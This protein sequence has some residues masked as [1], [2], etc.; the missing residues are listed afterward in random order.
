MSFPL[1]S[2]TT[3][4]SAWIGCGL[5]CLIAV[6]SLADDP[7]TAPV[8]GEFPA[9]SDGVE[10]MGE[11]VA[12]DPNNRRG[13]LRPGGEVTPDRYN[14]FPGQPFALLPYGA[15]YYHGAPAE[16]KDIPPGTVLH[17]VFFRPPK[18]DNS[19]PKPE[20]KSVAERQR[21]AYF[22]EHTHALLLEDSVSY[23]GRQG[24]AWRVERIETSEQDG[25]QFLVVNSVGKKATAGP[26]GE[27]KFCIDKSSR[28]WKGKESR[29]LDDVQP[30]QTVQLNLTW[31]PAWGYGKFHVLDLWL[32]QQAL[33]VAAERQRQTHLRYQQHHWLPGW[34]DKV[35]YEPGQ[36]NGSGVVEVTLFAG[37]DAALYKEV[38]ESRSAQ[39]AIAE[40]T[41]RTFRKDQDAQGGPIVEV[42]KQPGAPPGSSGMQLRVRVRHVLEG[43]RQGGIVRVGLPGF[44]P[45]T[46]PPEERATDR[47][48]IFSNP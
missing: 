22:K 39:L 36:P 46:L 31:D 13:L 4:K 6:A 15:V 11:L 14:R 23:Y 28:V 45:S 33:D 3:W 21:A 7:A 38:S 5:S 18:G 43:F 26:S 10:V 47:S 30:G 42:K 8:Y 25:R 17:G 1:P 9:L 12:V 19:I 24:Q 40:P 27:Q 20:P 48:S 35:T 32:D 2:R 41:L 37:L 44:P 29:A 34:V 16:L